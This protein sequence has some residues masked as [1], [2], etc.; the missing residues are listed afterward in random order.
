VEKVLGKMSGELMRMVLDEAMTAC[1]PPA[2]LHG[3]REARRRRGAL[4]AN[5]LTS[6]DDFIERYEKSLAL[7][8]LCLLATDVT[9]CKCQAVFS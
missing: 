5:A 9:G 4:A 2:G 6:T 1:P 7:K 3:R 8:T